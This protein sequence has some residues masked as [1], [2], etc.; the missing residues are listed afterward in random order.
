MFLKSLK[1]IDNTLKQYLEIG[2]KGNQDITLL[3]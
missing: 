1:Q 3:L 2:K